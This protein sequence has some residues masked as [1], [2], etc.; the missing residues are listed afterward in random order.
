MEAYKLALSQRT[1]IASFIG[2][3]DA[4]LKERLH[5]LTSDGNDVA[6]ISM[7]ELSGMHTDKWCDTL[8][9]Q[10]SAVYKQCDIAYSTRSQ[11]LDKQHYQE[12]IQ[13]FCSQQF[14][15]ESGLKR[16]CFYVGLLRQ[17]C[18]AHALLLACNATL[19]VM[20][21]K[22][23]SIFTHTAEQAHVS[24]L[25]HQLTLLDI[26][27]LIDANTFCSHEALTQELDVMGAEY[28]AQTRLYKAIDK[29]Q[30][31]FIRERE[32]RVVMDALLAE[33]LR[34]TE[35]EFGFVGDVLYKDDGKPYLKLRSLTDISWNEDTKAL[36]DKNEQE[37]LEFHNLDNLLGATMLADDHVIA[38]Q[39]QQDGRSGGT[40][41]GHPT[42]E[43]YLGVQ[44]RHRGKVVGMV[45][46]ANRPQGYTDDIVS[47]LTPI[48]DT[49]ELLF[50]ARVTKR[51]LHKSQ[52]RNQQLALIV[53]QTINGVV[54]TNPEFNI[55]W[56]NPAFIAM[57]GYS[58]DELKGCKPWDLLAGTDTDDSA[59]NA[60][61]QAVSERRPVS[62]EL[63]K[64]HKS[65]RKFWVSLSCNPTF[66]DMGQHTGFISIELDITQSHQQ[67]DALSNF[68]SVV[69]QTLDAVIF[70]D[71]QT[72]QIEYA[73]RGAQKQLGRSEEELKA[74]KPYQLKPKFTEQQLRDLLTPLVDGT[75]QFI[76]FYAEHETGD[77]RLVPSE[78]SMQCIRSASGKQVITNVLRDI[79]AQ[80]EVERMRLANEQQIEQLLQRSDDAMAVINQ[81]NRITECNQAALTLFA[82]PN[83][84]DFIGR[85]PT[86]M[87]ENTTKKDVQRTAFANEIDKAWTNGYR[88]FE[89]A[90]RT[91][92]G[93]NTPIE[94]T[95]NPIIHKGV[96]SLQLTWRDLTEAK[97]QQVR[98]K[99]LAYFDDMTGL[100]NKNLFRDRI[101]Y[102]IQVGQRLNYKIAV[103]YLDINNLTDINETLG[104]GAGDDVIRAVGKRLARTTRSSD[105]LS[106]Y[107]YE[108]EDLAAMQ[109]SELHNRE[110]DSL[111]RINGDIFAVAAVIDNTDSA[112]I[113]VSRLV[114][115]LA[116]P[117]N[118]NG[119][120]VYVSV[121]S[122]IALYPQDADN[123]E[124]LLRGANIALSQARDLN[125]GEYY[126][127]KALGQDIQ[128]RALTLKKL[129]LA[130][131]TNSDDIYINFQ[132]QITLNNNR[133]IGA[134]VLMRWHDAELG[135]VSPA[136]FIP[137]AEER[138]LI[139]DITSW[140][141]VKV[142]RQLLEWRRN[143]YNLTE[144][145]IKLAL[146]ISAKGLH[147]KDV[148]DQ[149]LAIMQQYDI[150]PDAFELE[151]TETG[152]MLDPEVSVGRLH[153]LKDLGFHI[154]I[155]DFGVGQSSLSYLQNISADLLKIDMCFVRS[156]LSDSTNHAIV[157]TIISMAGIFGMKTLAE[158]IEDA[159]ILAE[160]AG[161]GCE[162][163]QGYH[164]A[165]PLSADE[166]AALWLAKTGH[167]A[168]AE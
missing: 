140:L 30:V 40:P 33:L 104:Y 107:V 8:I 112:S 81:D 102:L 100:A 159:D 132:P 75:T 79:S 70:F 157:E 47:S 2:L 138:G 94:L 4:S 34:Y 71:A 146:N 68:K 142:C 131:Q 13:R 151:L 32:D 78:V 84:A 69:D 54:M 18:S 57:T 83:K 14:T 20:L 63:Q 43:R 125:Q 1:K 64:Y 115:V 82:C 28:A 31:A 116:M 67:K 101:N 88:R 56:C 61:K 87:A 23:P 168:L 158:G 73:N 26:S 144:S 49:L 165:K 62:L 141:F 163:G 72:L 17:G 46:L 44:L 77:G 120:D 110:F 124:S 53:K 37:G 143:G 35:S 93:C 128:R 147:R 76:R 111:A 59:L 12:F 58:L 66:D 95:L 10:F 164:I 122:G 45:G 3:D 52:Q 136:I 98:I 134:E 155:D 127:N 103:V 21:E 167:S 60:Y 149:Y 130:L 154:A 113:L 39:P 139:N 162:Y 7:P 137:L 166:F 105:T 150:Q 36:Y 161:M 118:I 89:W 121:R 108:H 24:L 80:Q 42:I 109:N 114:N 41:H 145:G 119:S 15:V 99:Q 19:R 160:L 123:E 91:F 51:A 38:N 25:F 55:T 16:V 85:S 5:R 133:L 92:R 135:Q 74:L 27:F 152:I 65:G 22:L 153:E 50:D 156:L 129:E 29:I 48:T 96:P 6:E 97:Q 9:N 90:H 117:F 86:E 126:Y 148:V 11:A 106:R